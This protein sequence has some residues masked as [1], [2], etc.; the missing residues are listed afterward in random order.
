MHATTQSLFSLAGKT[1]LVTGASSGLGAHFASVLAAAGA[2]VV[3]AARRQERLDS[4][5]AQITDNGGKA[6]AVAM[7]VTDGDSVNAAL[8]EAVDAFAAV[9]ILVNNAGVAGSRFCLNVDER[10]W[11]YIMDTNLKGAWRVAQA[12]AARSVAAHRPCSIINIAS[13]LGLRVGFGES[14]YGVS[15]AGVVQLTRA[16][17]LELAAKD[18]R[19]NAICPGYFATEMNSDYL[20]SEEGQAYLERTP[21]R[22]MGELDELSGPLLLLASGAGSFVN[23][24]IIPV[25]GGHLVSSL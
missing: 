4:L 16:L 1:A 5:V 22:R 9:D 17:A 6:T 15:K 13:I 20:H 24:A 8:D 2:N 3:A 23:G 21:A 12:V 11:D 14:A 19:V 18:I 7:D 10:N 25:D